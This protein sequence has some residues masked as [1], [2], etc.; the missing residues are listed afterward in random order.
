MESIHIGGLIGTDFNSEST[1]AI[2]R[3]P[4]SPIQ[5]SE[6]KRRD[7]SGPG[8]CGHLGGPRQCLR[9]DIFPDFRQFAIPDGNVED[10]V[11]LKRPI[12]RLDFPRG[13]AD[14]QNPVSLG[15]ELG[16]LWVRSFYRFVSFLE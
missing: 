2:I 13:E 9:V 3:W 12:R 7:W 6:T 8:A 14:D 16:G 1:L 11:V 5:I 15:Y 4:R 10:P